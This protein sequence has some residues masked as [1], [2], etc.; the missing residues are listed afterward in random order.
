MSFALAF[1]RYPFLPHALCSRS[2]FL[3]ASPPLFLPPLHL[4]FIPMPPFLS[5]VLSSVLSSILLH[6]VAFLPRSQFLLHFVISP[7]VSSLRSSFRSC[8]LL[9]HVSSFLAL[10]IPSFS[11]F[12]YV[13]I[14]PFLPWLVFSLHPLFLLSSFLC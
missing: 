13:V 6:S 5:L 4:S 8:S 10:F 3:S 12:L 2:S 7:P 9:F 11:V 1:F 14:L